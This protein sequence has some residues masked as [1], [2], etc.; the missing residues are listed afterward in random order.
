MNQGAAAADVRR[1]I[2]R[3]RW[4]KINITISV[5]EIKF[6]SFLYFSL[7]RLSIVIEGTNARVCV[8]AHT[9]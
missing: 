4:K 6:F 8:R 9:W 2:L 5:K 7:G 1:E 3:R